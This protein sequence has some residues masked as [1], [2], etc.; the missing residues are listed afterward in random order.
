MLAELLDCPSYISESG[1]EEEKA[2][3]LS[4][5]IADKG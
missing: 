4:G 5:W 3:I 1:S 2:A